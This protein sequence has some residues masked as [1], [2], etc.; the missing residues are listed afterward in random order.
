[1]L[2]LRVELKTSRL[3]N[4]CSNQLSYESYSYYAYI[5]D[6]TCGCLLISFECCRIITGHTRGY[7]CIWD[8]QTQASDT[9]L[10]CKNIRTK[11]T[12][13]LINRL[14]LHL[15]LSTICRAN[16]NTYHVR[17]LPNLGAQIVYISSVVG[18]VNSLWL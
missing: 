1:M 3:L 15:Y 7:V 4:G 6:I 10:Q 5:R 11:S 17:L 12:I 2:S 9:Y 14:M 18:V 13:F 8:G 16:D